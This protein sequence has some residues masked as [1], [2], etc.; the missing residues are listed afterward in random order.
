MSTTATRATGEDRQLTTKMVIGG[1][2]ARSNVARTEIKNGD[3]IPYV[4]GLSRD[5]RGPR[6]RAASITPTAATLGSM[7]AASSPDFYGWVFPP[8]EIRQGSASMG[9]PS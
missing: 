1:D 6:P 7:T 5:R 4:I 8:R 2:G 9:R 3:K